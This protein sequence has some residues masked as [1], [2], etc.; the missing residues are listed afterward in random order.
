MGAPAAALQPDLRA[1]INLLFSRPA[2]VPAATARL[3]VRCL[4]EHA[5]VPAD[6]STE[7]IEQAIRKGEESTAPTTLAGIVSPLTP[8]AAA[9][10]GY[11]RVV[12]P[13]GGIEAEP[14]LPD[15]VQ[16]AVSPPG[17]AYTYVEVPDIIRVGAPATG[18]LAQ[19]RT[20]LFGS[21]ESWLLVDQ[22]AVAGIRRF[23]VAAMKSPEV[24]EAA[25]A[26]ERCMAERGYASKNPADTARQ[27]RLRWIESATAGEPTA[28]E[29]A[30]ARA[31]ADCQRRS[32]VHAV[33]DDTVLRLAATW[34]RQHESTILELADTYTAAIERAQQVMGQ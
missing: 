14:G 9:E 25:A 19:V 5:V 23:A 24:T 22:F 32:G 21:V 8:E 33:L 16:A 31:D 18:C 26:Y 34:I 4:V 17:A 13:H 27:A 6:G 30:M 20:A 28:D 29:I 11:R 1:A 12:A 15:A 10:H 2:V 7:Q 3:A